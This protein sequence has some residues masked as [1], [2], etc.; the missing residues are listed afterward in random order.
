MEVGEGQAKTVQEMLLSGGFSEAESRQDSAGIE[1]VV[2]GQ[3]S[4]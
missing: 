2:I 1:R 4:E 3:L